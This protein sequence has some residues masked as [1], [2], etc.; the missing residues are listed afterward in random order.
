MK[1]FV[2]YIFVQQISMT[3]NGCKPTAVMQNCA[4]SEDCSAKL[5]SRLSWG[6][7]AHEV[8]QQ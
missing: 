7:Y 5:R 2:L 1:H 3:Q 4:H 6:V 8:N